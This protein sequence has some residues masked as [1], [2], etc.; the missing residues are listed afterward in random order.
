MFQDK[1]KDGSIIGDFAD[2]V[3]D[4]LLNT[5]STKE[6]KK[7]ITKAFEGF[8]NFKE[9]FYS[10]EKGASSLNAELLLSRSRISEFKVTIADTLPLV[11]KLGGDYTETMKVIKGSIDAMGRNV[12]FEPEIYEKLF[13]AQTLI[14]KEAST[15]ITNF[16]EA[17]IMASKIGSNLEK[18]LDYI[19]TVGVNA[20][21]V[22]GNVVD[23]TEM[24]NRFSFQ[25]GVLGFTKM[26]AQASI[27]KVN[28]TTI[29]N[30]A[31]KVFEPEGAIDMAAA[32][33]RLGVFVGDLADPF[34]LMNKSLN[35]P[36]GLIMSVAKA[37]EKFTQFNEEAGRFEINPSAMNQMS[38]MADAVGMNAA[39]FKKM[40]LNLAEFN[41]RASEID[42]K[43]NLTDEQKM[44]VANLAY[45]DTDNEYKIKVTDEK[46]G[47][48]IA[49][50]VKDLTEK[51]ISQLNELSKQEPKTLEELT[52]DSMDIVATI[53][54]D[55]GAIKYKLLF[56]A[57][58][59]QSIMGR[60]QE[61]IRTGAGD[62]GDII[63]KGVPGGET[64]RETIRGVVNPVA[65]MYKGEDFDA[66]MEKIMQA[67]GRYFTEIPKNLSE[68][69]KKSKELGTMFGTGYG[70]EALLDNSNKMFG[71]ITGS[72]EK[73]FNIQSAAKIDGGE[74]MKNLE[75][76]IKGVQDTLNNPKDLNN[77]LTINL[78]VKQTNNAGAV[79]SKSSVDKAVEW[80][81]SQDLVADLSSFIE[82]FK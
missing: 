28:M 4:V 60:V 43:F 38:K 17:G 66:N 57:V 73:I 45:L 20:K 47:E 1:P 82:T 24:L 53:A 9:A 30:I 70:L 63:Y 35:D 81:K 76:D 54:S 14:G 77:K 51:Q 3:F 33:Q 71:D 12:I 36:E 74:Q 5:I 22:M 13:A 58:S 62:V 2:K 80:V 23:N 6:D 56:G 48:S 25:E 11:A 72:M 34:M 32:F 15:M 61:G 10:L 29:S 64:T 78:N 26:A 79:I 75:K 68:G 52:R 21:S 37:G 16:G 19:R 8:G 65:N 69:I 31:D 42:I 55:V 67:V 18:S 50:A 40:S 49:T 27:L 44:F 41:A 59:E 46:T 7:R 39:E